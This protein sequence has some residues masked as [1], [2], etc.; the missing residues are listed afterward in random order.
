M[1]NV[2]LT[3][4]TRVIKNEA[5]SNDVRYAE[6]DTRDSMKEF[7]CGNEALILC[8]YL[9]EKLVVSSGYTEMVNDITT[10]YYNNL[11]KL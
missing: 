9:G 1:S 7:V 8:T 3:S 11:H 5:I 2:R 10:N 6:H 4:R